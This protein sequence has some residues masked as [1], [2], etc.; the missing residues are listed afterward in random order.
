MAESS[1]LPA[2]AEIAF[3]SPEKIVR[4]RR[5]E[6]VHSIPN[7]PDALID[8][9]NKIDAEAS[10]QYRIVE[11]YVVEEGV[12]RPVYAETPVVFVSDDDGG[13]FEFYDAGTHGAPYHPIPERR[14]LETQAVEKE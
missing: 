4:E 7:D 11:E 12:Q 10:G 9:L 14:G 13:H 6:A 1:R 8:A 5:A 3:L 2:D